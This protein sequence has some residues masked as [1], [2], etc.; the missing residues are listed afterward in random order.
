[1]T[2]RYHSSSGRPV[3]SVTQVLTRAGRLSSSFYT[4]DAAERGTRIHQ[5]T[6]LFDLGTLPAS[7]ASG[8]FAYLDAYASFV[9]IAKPV[10]AGTERER[11]SETYAFAGRIDREVV[12]LFGRPCPRTVLDIK[13]GDPEKW[14]RY[15]LAGYG[16]LAHTAYRMA[17]YLRPS[18]RYA[19]QPF[20]DPTDDRQFISDLAAVHRLL[21]KDSDQWLQPNS[22]L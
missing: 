8:D 5:L 12:S 19:L 14:H 6:E 9:G 1:M 15:Q 7:I 18:G 21:R 22:C 11:V 4:P 2:P 20:T 16:R 10:Y 17:L 13:T 3:V